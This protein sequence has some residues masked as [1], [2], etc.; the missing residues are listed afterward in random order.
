EKI[1]A[2]KNSVQDPE[3]QKHFK[4]LETVFIS[5]Q[6]DRKPEEAAVL[7]NIIIENGLLEENRVRRR[8]Y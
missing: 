6:N 5:M 4:R 3:L 1:R 7:K 2:N 8:S